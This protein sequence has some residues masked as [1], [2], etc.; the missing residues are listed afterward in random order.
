M[1]R[2]DEI[3]EALVYARIPSD[4]RLGRMKWRRKIAWVIT[5]AIM[6]LNY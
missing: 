2:I 5:T 4:V 3:E 6:V 1:W